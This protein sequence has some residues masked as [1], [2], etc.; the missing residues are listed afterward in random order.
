ML[1][2][3]YSSTIYSQVIVLRILLDFGFRAI[4]YNY[5]NRG[6][7]LKIIDSSQ[8]WSS[9]LSASEWFY[10]KPLRDSNIESVYNRVG[11]TGWD[12][13]YDI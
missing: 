10:I 11:V 7:F 8:G 3:S 6:W 13:F 4:Y 2:F 12:D 5:L 1:K 9:S